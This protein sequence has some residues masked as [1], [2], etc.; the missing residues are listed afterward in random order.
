MSLVCAKAKP[1]SI[2]P[3]ASSELIPLTKEAIGEISSVGITFVAASETHC[4]S[5]DI[6]RE[7]EGVIWQH[8]Y[9]SAY[10]HSHAPGIPNHQVYSY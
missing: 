7:P 3:K 1:L 2:V 10:I 8:R 9:C 5:R 6:R 4:S